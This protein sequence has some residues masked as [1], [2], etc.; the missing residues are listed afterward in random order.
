LDEFEYFATALDGDMQKLDDCLKGQTHDRVSVGA[1]ASAPVS[2][3]PTCTA[4]QRTELIA[5]ARALTLRRLVPS[6]RRIT[7]E[8][9]HGN[10]KLAARDL[11]RL[12]SHVKAEARRAGSLLHALNACR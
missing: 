6:A 11:T 7:A 8:Y 4:A 2:A 1:R 9:K 12:K 5:R 3:T 10:R